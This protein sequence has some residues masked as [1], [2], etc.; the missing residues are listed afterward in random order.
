[1]QYIP[2][3]TWPSTY[4][5]TQAVIREVHKVD[6]ETQLTPFYPDQKQC[7]YAMRPLRE[8][9]NFPIDPLQVEESPGSCLQELLIPKHL[10]QKWIVFYLNYSILY[11][12]SIYTVLDKFLNEC[13]SLSKWR[14]IRTPNG[15]TENSGEC[16][17]MAHLLSLPQILSLS[18][19]DFVQFN[20]FKQHQYANDTPTYISGPDLFPSDSNSQFLLLILC[21]HWGT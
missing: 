5:I 6:S 20:G 19:G 12:L 15:S 7:I 11:L 4:P 8:K 14:I 1:M 3:S 2:D 13:H 17:F 18:P 21:L 16:L 9:P 10:P